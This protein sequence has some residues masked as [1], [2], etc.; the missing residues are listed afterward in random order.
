[1]GAPALAMK[2]ICKRFPGTEALKNVDFAVQPGAVHALIGANGAGKSTLMNVL[3]G[4]HQKD[5]GVIEVNGAK[6]E[7]ATPHEALRLGIAIVPQ[8]LSLVPELSVA[9]N[10]FLGN[11]ARGGS[12]LID[13]KETRRRAAELLAR[14]GVTLDVDQRLGSLSAAYQQLVSIARALAFGSRI[15]ILD[16]PTAALTAHET[17]LLFEVMRKL[18]QEGASIVFITHHLDEVKAVADGITIMRDGQVVYEGEAAALSIPDMVFH[19]A[20]RRVE[21]ERAT[22]SVITGKP[23]LEVR[24][25]GRK[26]EFR[27]VSFQVRK[28]EILG[29]AGLVGAGR[30]ELCNALFGVT[31]KDAGT[32]LLDGTEVDIESPRAAIELGLG[33]VPEERR[34]MALFAVLSVLENMLLPSLDRVSRRGFI[35]YRQCRQESAGF[36]Q[37]L[38]IKT[39]SSDVPIRSLSGGNQQKVVLARWMAKQ[40]RLLILDE[41]TR[42]IDV[43]AKSE[44]HKLVRG[45]AAQGVAVIVVSSEAEEVLA[46][47]DRVMVM[48]EG[49][50]KGFLD[51]PGA[52][53]PHDILA[54]AI[55]SEATA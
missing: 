48:H 21:F 46:L 18:R 15:L 11:F 22:R 4:V 1:M 2:G 3:V 40:V 19:M 32:T 10:V 42:G 54:V 30:T 51:D 16:E 24:G 28:G 44:I 52:H 39:P 38:R 26:G 23:F 14:I 7:H 43:N 8:E 50:V 35:D 12:G 37:S 20:N 25:L 17:E 49:R 31:H 9:E 55:A 13:W 36:V 34:R 45:L 6:V 5:A 53:T 29:I 47:A 33:Y 27:D 41:P